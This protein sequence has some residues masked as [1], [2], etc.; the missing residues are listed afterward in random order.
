MS[1]EPITV[2]LVDDHAAGRAGVRRLLEQETTF[3]VIAEAGS[4]GPCWPLLSSTV[5]FCCDLGHKPLASE[6][7]IRRRQVAQNAYIRRL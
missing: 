7:Y 3:Q 5:V 6:G 1:R 2:M 4:D